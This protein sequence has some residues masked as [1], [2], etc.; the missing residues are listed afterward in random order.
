MHSW[1][2]EFDYSP[3]P[4][5]PCSEQLHSHITEILDNH[6][7]LENARGDPAEAVNPVAA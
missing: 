6:H 7:A 4:D 2:D 5:N 3:F 1:P